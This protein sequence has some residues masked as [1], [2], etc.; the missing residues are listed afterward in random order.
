MSSGAVRAQMSQC[1]VEINECQA[2]IDLL[3][4]EISDLSILYASRNKAF[5]K[6]SDD[7]T[8]RRRRLDGVAGV[9]DKA[10]AARSYLPGMDLDLSTFKTKVSA[11]GDN[12][13]YIETEKRNRET[14]VQ[15]EQSTLNA[16]NGRM[17]S[18]QGELNY[19]LNREAEEAAAAAATAAAEAAQQ[20]NW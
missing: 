15:D 7:Y 20:N 5:L 8:L 13:D 4:R 12:L 1:Q 19:W 11:L 14:K 18:L 10:K 9:S 3:H 17:A 16:L 2:R 6:A